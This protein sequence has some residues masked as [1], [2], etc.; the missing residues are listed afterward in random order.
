MKLNILQTPIEIKDKISKPLLPELIKVKE[1]GD[2]AKYV[3]GSVITNLLNNTFGPLGWS[4]EIKD[5]WIEPS[6]PFVNR[7]KNNEEEKQAPNVFVH[8]RLTVYIQCEDGSIKEVYRESY[9]SKSIVG[10]QA[11]QASSFKAAQTDALKKCASMFGFASEVYTSEEDYLLLAS[12]NI[13]PTWTNEILEK[14]KEQ[15]ELFNTISNNNDEFT[16]YMN[17]YVSYLTNGLTEDFMYIP[18][19]KIDELYTALTSNGEE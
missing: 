11:E 8:G 6:I 4:F 3:S 2:K 18:E 5:K 15:Y 9:G 10:K 14:Y 7:Y 12:M 13:E 19:D 17:Q 1:Y 16:V